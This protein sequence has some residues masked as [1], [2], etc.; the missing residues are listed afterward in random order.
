MDLYQN[1]HDE[2]M[3]ISVFESMVDRLIRVGRKRG[4]FSLLEILLNGTG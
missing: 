2:A 4:S 3:L 1:I